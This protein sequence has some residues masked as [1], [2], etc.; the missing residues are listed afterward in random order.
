[1]SLIDEELGKLKELLDKMA[2]VAEGGYV[3]SEHTNIFIDYAST[4]IDA[5]KKL[6]EAYKSKTGKTLEVVER[7]IETA[8][9]RLKFIAKVKYGDIV[10]TRDHNIIADVLKNIEIGLIEIDRNL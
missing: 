4:S 6:Y 7:C 1:M 5:L 8:E 2:Y 3:L 9:T 10:A